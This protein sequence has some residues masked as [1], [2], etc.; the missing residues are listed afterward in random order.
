MTY[1]R[2]VHGGPNYTP[3]EIYAFA[4]PRKKRIVISRL[5]DKLICWWNGHDV[6][7]PSAYYFTG[8]AWCRRCKEKI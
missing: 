2:T 8:D 4:T 5:F 3:E 1:E 6:F 7:T